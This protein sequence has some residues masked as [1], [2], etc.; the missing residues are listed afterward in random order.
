MF[1]RPRSLAGIAGRNAL[2]RRQYLAQPLIGVA[3][4]LGRYT[5]QILNP[6]GTDRLDEG[7]SGHHQAVDRLAALAAVIDNDIVLYAR[8]LHQRIS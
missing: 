5:I 4:E 2:R 3:V 7:V 6:D 8:A 1:S